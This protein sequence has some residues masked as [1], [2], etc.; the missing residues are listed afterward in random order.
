MDLNGLFTR[1]LQ[2]RTIS[3]LY[4]SVF[5]PS[6]FPK[7]VSAHSCRLG[8]LRIR[9]LI[10]GALT[11]QLLTEP[12]GLEIAR[13]YVLAGLGIGASGGL[14]SCNGVGWRS[15]RGCR[16]FLY[17]VLGRRHGAKARGR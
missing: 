2:T 4:Q 10:R 14:A 16:V 9:I 1:L 5:V 15:S 12:T 11:S 13:K 3:A 8:L 17:V 7:H 6:P